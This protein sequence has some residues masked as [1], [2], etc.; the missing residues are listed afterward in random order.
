MTWETWFKIEDI[1]EDE[2]L[3]WPVAFISGLAVFLL[4]LTIFLGVFITAR[5]LSQSRVS[6]TLAGR[7]FIVILALSC[8][9]LSV[10]V[11]HVALDSF[12]TWYN[13]PLGSSLE[14]VLK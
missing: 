1:I 5:I 4:I 10:W 8:G 3:H 9:L 13:T 2:A 12:V 6:P 7:Y 11:S 14:L